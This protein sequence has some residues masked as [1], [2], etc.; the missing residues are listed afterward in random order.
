ME[1]A[2]NMVYGDAVNV[3][4]VLLQWITMVAMYVASVVTRVLVNKRHFIEVK[5]V[6]A[7][8]M[9]VRSFLVLRTND[10]IV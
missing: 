7:C 4:N 8:I 9:L 2:E 1:H 10:T 5:N 6:I 3:V